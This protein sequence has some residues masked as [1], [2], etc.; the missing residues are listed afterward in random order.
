MCISLLYL[1]T[2]VLTD[3]I[4][5]LIFKELFPEYKVVDSASYDDG[6]ILLRVT[7][8]N[9][10]CNSQGVNLR[11]IHPN[12]SISSINLNV[13]IPDLNYC[14][15]TGNA[16]TKKPEIN[17]SGTSTSSTLDTTNKTSDAIRIYAIIDQYI[18]VTYF[19]KL[20]DSF[21][22]CGLVLTW[23][24]RI[25]SNMN[26]GDMCTD[27]EFVRNI[28]TI[29][30]NFLRVCYIS[31]AQ[32][33]IWTKYSSPDVTTGTINVISNGTLNNIS[34][35]NRDI[36][37]IFP[38]EDGGYAQG[39]D[40]KGPFQI[41]TRSID[42]MLTIR[43]VSCHIS[44]VSLGYSCLI[45]INQASNLIL[46]DVDFLSSGSVMNT[47]EFVIDPIISNVWSAL[48]LYYGGNCIIATN[49]TDGSVTGVVYSDDGKLHG[50]WGLPKNYFYTYS[51]GVF[52]NNTVWAIATNSDGWSVV[53]SSNLTTYS[54]IQGSSVGLAS[55]RNALV[56]TT[57]PV[58]NSKISPTNITTVTITFLNDVKMSD[59]NISIWEF[60][61]FFSIL[62][63]SFS[64]NQSQYVQLFSNKT[65]VATVLS[66]T[67]NRENSTYYITID[68]GFVK[69]AKVDQ[70]LL[71][72]S[73]E[74][75]KD[76]DYASAIVRFT[77]EG[78]TFYENLSSQ[79]QSKFSIEF[80]RQLASIIPCDPERIST[81][82]KYQYDRS[83]SIGQILFR[84]YIGRPTSSSEAN[85]A[86]II[87]DMDTLI[88]NKAVTQ[89]SK[90]SNTFYLDSSFGSFRAREQSINNIFA[91][92]WQ[93]YSKTALVFILISGLDSDIL[94]FMASKVAGITA[95]S[96]PFLWK[97]RK[98]VCFWNLFILI[99]EDIS[100]FIILILYQHYT[101]LPEI[102][103]ILVLASYDI[104]SEPTNLHHVKRGIRTNGEEIVV[105]ND[106][107]EIRKRGSSPETEISE[108]V[109]L[110][111]NS[112]GEP[113]FSLRNPEEYRGPEVVQRSLKGKLVEDSIINIEDSLFEDM[114]SNDAG[115]SGLIG[116]VYGGIYGDGGRNSSSSKRLS[117]IG[118]IGNTDELSFE[119][120]ATTFSEFDLEENIAAFSEFDFGGIYPQTGINIGIE[121]EL[122]TTTSSFTFDT[123]Q[124]SRA[125]E[126]D[127]TTVRS[128]QTINT[129]IGSSEDN[130]ERDE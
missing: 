75:N 66:S 87:Q 111:T 112:V 30:G 36:S 71:D 41:Y 93:Q 82:K 91:K 100:Q 108:S 102:V 106:D 17:N 52:P 37:K 35:F 42:I 76:D 107:D 117:N 9:S 68:N 59:G 120:N 65:V 78:S 58:I 73:L 116:D 81:T 50:P 56:Q 5:V 89:I 19:C 122:L 6:T 96:A 63:Q 95:F 67:F 103:P 99:I 105:D 31:D 8:P 3:D 11:L 39:T 104:L 16:F 115:G 72:F 92:W 119:E 10:G 44:Y 94:N 14:S 113:V 85:S 62:R 114:S 4:N 53:S 126:M 45:H 47:H 12:G 127:S 51:V 121:S 69:D 24:S 49:T 123:F 90:E 7:R 128:S 60:G 98:I 70:Q 124:R 88:R 129:Q 27:S 97:T 55:Y 48:P 15:I 54:T 64:G 101:V 110:A 38:T 22:I 43:I 80:S 33:V 130:Q 13:S 21:D 28:N 79:D 26:F 83:V 23:D 34:R 84:V 46:V 29:D 86:K 1:V 109:M 125:L 77:P 57:F 20:P 118:V 18:L 74:N 32:K 40:T 25:L 61:G 2:Q